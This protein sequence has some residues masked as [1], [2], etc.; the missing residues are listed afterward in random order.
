MISASRPSA[1]ARSTGSPSADSSAHSSSAVD[2]QRAVPTSSRPRLS[3]AGELQP[4]RLERLGGA[5]RPA[6]CELVGH[7]EQVGLAG[8]G[9]HLIGRLPV[10]ASPGVRRVRPPAA[11]Q[12][13]VHRGDVPAGRQP[14]PGRHQPPRGLLR[15]D[16]P[17]R[18]DLLVGGRRRPRPSPHSPSPVS[19]HRERPSRH[20]PHDE[21]DEVARASRP[22][23]GASTASPR[24][25][26]RQ[27]LSA[28]TSSTRSADMRP[29][30][31]S[32]ADAVT[33]SGRLVPVRTGG[34]PGQAPRA[35]AAGE[36]SRARP[37][38]WSG[39]SPPGGLPRGRAP[40]DRLCPQPLRARVR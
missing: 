36:T 37:G 25:P 5:E 15:P 32:R 19:G 40:R 6:L 20:A 4:G 11:E 39:N 30:R 31:R 26:T 28:I 12:Q 34:L 1:A 22:S 33:V 3:E 2:S 29:P 16:H 27:H 21:P 9:G 24:S 23:F 7:A 18:P 10:Q 17:P 38:G 8:D 13:P 14:H 35:R